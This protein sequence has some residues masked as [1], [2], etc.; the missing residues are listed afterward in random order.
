MTSYSESMATVHELRDRIGALRK[1]MRAALRATPPEPVEDYV[2]AGPDGPVR[3]SQLFGDKKDLFVIHNM[4]RGCVYCTMWADGFNGV[5]D[6]LSNRAA[7][8]VSSPDAPE[9]QREFAASRGWR[10][11]MV[12]HAGTTFA[13]DMGFYGNGGWQPGVSAFRRTE[14]GIE[15]VS[16]T[17]LGPGDDFCSVWHF[18]D[19]LPEG[20][21]GWT[22]KFRYAS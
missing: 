3:L 21:G 4:G 12:S 17:E 8:V 13:A 6:H 16:D 11:P 19:L 10:F 15:R 5:Y 9:V 2:F 20:A 1:E 14:Q 22:P 7:F 18:L